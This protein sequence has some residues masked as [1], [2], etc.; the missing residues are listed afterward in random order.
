[1][2]ARSDLNEDKRAEQLSAVLSLLF[3][4]RWP[5]GETEIMERSMKFS[6]IEDLRPLLSDLKRA[7]LIADL[8]PGNWKLTKK[9]REMVKTSLV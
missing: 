4:F 2:K 1:M 7:E 9:G 5:M 8:A 6:D 3:E